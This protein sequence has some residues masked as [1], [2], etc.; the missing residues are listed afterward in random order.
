MTEEWR[1]KIVKKKASIVSLEDV[2][3]T[4]PSG[5]QAIKDLSIDI[6]KGEFVF[7]VGASGSGKST[8]V[9]LLL[10]EVKPTS[11]KIIVNGKNITYLKHKQVAAHRRRIG[12]VFQDFRL[13]KDRN[14]FENVAFAQKVVGVQNRLVGKNV[15]RILSL[16]G[17]SDKEKT[18]PRELSGGQQQRVALARALVNQPTLLIADEPT[19]N[20]DPKTSMEIMHL[21]EDINAQGTTVIVVTHDNEIVNQLQKRVIYLKEGQLHSDEENAKYVED[22]SIESAHLSQGAFESQ[23]DDEI[24]GGLR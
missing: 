2:T 4:Y 11:G 8:L 5:V 1:Y 13:L 17:V 22:L 3:M 14:V 20:L 10:C 6:A 19:G 23:E 18:F 15:R 9:K 12:C 24:W 7:I 16:V 21:L